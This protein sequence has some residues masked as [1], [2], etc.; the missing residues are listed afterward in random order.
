M[1]SFIVSE[2]HCISISGFGNH[3]PLSVII[4]IAKVHFILVE[5]L[6]FAVGILVISVI[7]SEM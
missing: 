1:M 7:H 5:N 2:I 6:R 4:G 3:F